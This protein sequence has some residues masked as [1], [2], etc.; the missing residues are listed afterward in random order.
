MGWNDE[1]IP[2][3]GGWRRVLVTGTDPPFQ[4]IDFNILF[5]V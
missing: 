2:D 1:W 5:D 3:E 4:S